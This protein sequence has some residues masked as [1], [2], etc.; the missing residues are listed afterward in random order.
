MVEKDHSRCG[1]RRT[2]GRPPVRP[3][4]I[5]RTGTPVAYDPAPDVNPNTYGSTSRTVVTDF[6]FASTVTA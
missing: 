5:G 1:A 2:A 3:F 4:L 6:T